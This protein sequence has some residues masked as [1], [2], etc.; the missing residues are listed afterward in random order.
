MA[1][2]ATFTNHGGI[3]TLLRADN[4]TQ[5]QVEERNAAAAAN[6]I[7]QR[8]NSSSWI[9]TSGPMDKSVRNKD[10]RS[11]DMLPNTKATTTVSD[12][13]RSSMKKII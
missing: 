3:R 4:A 10:W 8:I 12:F 2:S 13:L 11:R 7:S 6:F 1:E 9:L 5:Q